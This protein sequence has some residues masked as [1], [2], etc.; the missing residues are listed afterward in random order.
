MRHNEKRRY[1]MKLLKTMTA[2]CFITALTGA[3]AMANSITSWSC[4]YSSGT[5][6][7]TLT[8][9][10]AASASAVV[11]IDNVSQSG[12]TISGTTISVDIPTSTQCWAV[13]FT[14]TDGGTTF[15]LN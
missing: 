7:A 11:N 10:S 6:T 13:T 3:N 1:P 12:A 2:A 4:E 9:Q 8:T 15:G 14:V 5:Q